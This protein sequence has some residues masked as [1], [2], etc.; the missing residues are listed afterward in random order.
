MKLEQK[1]RNRKVI[2][3]ALLFVV[4]MFAFGYAL[5]PFYNLLCSTLGINGKTNTSAVKKSGAIDKSRLITVQFLATNNANLPWTFHPK[6]KEIE[7]HPGENVKFAYYAKNNSNRTMTVQ[8]IPSVTPGV[9]AT[10]LKKTECFCFHQRTLKPHE[11]MD[12]PIVFHIDNDLPE[13]IH[14]MTLSYTLFEAKKNQR[15]HNR[16]KGKL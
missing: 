12:M 16:P 13:N 11:S 2:F 5:V 6:K 7:I 15:N 14:E 8:A 1:K 3:F 10:Y 9:A 4:V